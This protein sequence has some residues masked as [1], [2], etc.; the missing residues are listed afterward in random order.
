MSLSSNI[1]HVSCVDFSIPTTQSLGGASVRKW[2]S[3]HRRIFIIWP[4]SWSSESRVSIFSNLFFKL[5]ISKL[6]TITKYNRGQNHHKN[7]IDSFHCLLEIRHQENTVCQKKG[8]GLCIN[9]RVHVSIIMRWCALKRMLEVSRTLEVGFLKT[10]HLEKQNIKDNRSNE[11]GMK[12]ISE[13]Q[14]F[15]REEGRNKRQKTHSHPDPKPSTIFNVDHLRFFPTLSAASIT[16]LKSVQKLFSSKNLEFT[17]KPLQKHGAFLLGK[18][19]NSF[20][21][22]TFFEPITNLTPRIWGKPLRKR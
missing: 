16:F 8:H 15:S 19:A 10:Q 11:I 2:I 3:G 4:F 13:T 7:G 5:M 21:V 18:E 22:L 1:C 17:H 14:P 6:K 12:A 20:C 9:H